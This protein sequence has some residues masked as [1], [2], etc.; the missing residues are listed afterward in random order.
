MSQRRQKEFLAEIRRALARVQVRRG[1]SILVALSGG[2]DSVALL[3]AIAELGKSEEYRLRAAH[4]NHGLRGDESDRDEAFCRDLC[5][6]LNIEFI[7]ERARGLSLEMPNL[8]EAARYARH[9]FLNR[10]AEKTGADFIALGH[11]EDDQAETVLMR[12]LRGAGV[13]GLAAMAEA[14]PGR[15]I[16]PMLSIGRRDILDYL[17]SI[18]AE[19][20]TDSSN[21]SSAMLRNRVRIDLM[22][23]L[24]RDYAPE[25]SR[26]LAALAG[27]MRAVDSFL[28][29][30]A[31]QE[32]PAIEDAETGLD[33]MRFAQLDPALRIPV[34]RLF[35][36]AH[37]GSLRR[38]NR[39]H[40]DGLVA[41]CL[42]GPV[43]GEISLPG[44]WRASREY[45]RL[46]VVKDSRVAP[47]K[48]SE[49]IAFEGAT[50]VGEAGFAFEATVVG[51]GDIAMP[52]DHDSAIFDL[53][54]VAE[55]GLVAR[56]FR[57]GD[58][59]HPLGVAGTRK[60]KDV[61]IDK[62]VPP[63]DR[64]RFPIVAA[65]SDIVWLPGL[66]RGDGAL[67]SKTTET[68][69]RIKARRIER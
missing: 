32:F 66:L 35:L 24:D 10:T 56:S 1:A 61:F 41:L 25:V 12:L 50:E 31:A 23:M 64:A 63:G 68:A 36:A 58:R 45:Q 33:L 19:F 11:H 8:E 2:P 26:R 20:V 44:G 42:A 54:A 62:K 27:E 17:H 55:S 34:L 47:T 21:L 28:S 38:L 40:L 69:L 59:I 37:L 4:L 13:A 51:A 22:P 43:N 16:R 15:F 52:A 57:P 49:P 46:R 53:R 5:T 60:V 29:R 6:R 65:G 9:D 3:H 48:F 67:V 30:A 7:T 18:K 39:D 14:G